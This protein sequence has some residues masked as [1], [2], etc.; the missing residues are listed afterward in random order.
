MAAD[1]KIMTVDVKQGASF[2]A[3]AAKPLFQ[4]RPRELIS[5]TD[6]FAY[7]VS[8][9]GQS[10]LVNTDTSELKSN[11]VLTVVTNWTASL[12]K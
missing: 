1:G 9:D 12:K 6:L 3:G 7:D 11:T 5:S 8:A 2:E 4:T 10:F